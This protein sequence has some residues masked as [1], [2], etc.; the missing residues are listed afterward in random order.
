MADLMAPMPFIELTGGCQI[1]FESPGPTGSP[2]VGG[3]G[4]QQIVIWASGT[5]PGGEFGDVLPI[6]TSIPFADQV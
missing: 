6:L 3:V 1:V 5:G 2:D 4:V